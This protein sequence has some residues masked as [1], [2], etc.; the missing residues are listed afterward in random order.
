MDDKLA[1]FMQLSALLTGLKKQILDDDEDQKLFKPIAEEYLRRLSGAFSSKLPPPGNLPVVDY[2]PAF[3]GLLNAYTTLA[4]VSPKPDIND[5]LLVALQKTPEFKDKKGEFV[6]RQIVNI[7]YFSQFHA[8]EEAEKSGHFI[9][10]GFYERGAVWPLI[11]THPI[12]FSNQAT[13]YWKEKPK[14]VGGVS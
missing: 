1:F 4:S 13:G 8:S 2:L 9:D 11:K 10:G 5:K 6:A 14:S 3:D 7:W 12:G